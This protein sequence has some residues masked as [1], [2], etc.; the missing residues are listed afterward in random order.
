M[1]QTI[2]IASVVEQNEK[3]VLGK[4]VLF[5]PISRDS[6]SE[7]LLIVMSAHNQGNKYMALRS[8][9][10]NQVCDLLFI[11]DPKTPGTSTM[12]TEKLS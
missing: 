3:I 7:K 9:L 1:D 8:F 6:N 10:E 2:D 4:K 11:S 12:T 5:V